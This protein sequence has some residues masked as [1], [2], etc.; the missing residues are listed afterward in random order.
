MLVEE[1][2]NSDPVC[3]HADDLIETAVEYIHRH[4]IRHIPVVDNNNILTGIVSDRDIRDASPSIFH[5]RS[6]EEHL[7]NPVSRI[8]TYPVI[9]ASRLDVVEEAAFIL[10]DKDISALPVI[11]DDDKLAGIL[12]ETN[13]LHTLVELT[14]AHQP[15]SRIEIKVEDQPGELAVITSIFQRKRINVISVLVYPGKDDTHKY[16]S[17]RVQTMDPRDIIQTLEKAGYEVSWPRIPGMNE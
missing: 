15:S 3:I 6:R 13:V 2:M 9:T 14:G 10:Y 12:T 7:K 17:F 11:E 16:L 8:M 1:I 5:T 4:K